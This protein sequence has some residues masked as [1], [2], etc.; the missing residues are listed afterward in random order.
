MNEF[1]FYIGPTE[2]TSC[3]EKHAAVEI[4]FGNE[5]V[6]MPVSES[7]RFADALYEAGLK[8]AEQ[9]GNKQ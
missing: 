6:V 4:L 2:C 7:N 3:P 5:H 8:S 1:P 9:Y